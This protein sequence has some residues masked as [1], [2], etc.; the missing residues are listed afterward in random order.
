VV[1]L[2]FGDRVVVAVV[3]VAFTTAS[4]NSLET[5][6]KVVTDLD[7]RRSLKVYEELY[8]DVPSSID[9]INDK[10]LVTKLICGNKFL[11]DMELLD[12]R[13]Q[14]YAMENATKSEV[15]HQKYRGTIPIKCRSRKCIYLFFK[16]RINDALG[17]ESPFAE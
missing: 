6:K 16:K 1:K 2:N 4:A 14:V 10:R 8:G 17:G 5:Q 11:S 7:L 13:A 9:C 15:D 12:R 3:F